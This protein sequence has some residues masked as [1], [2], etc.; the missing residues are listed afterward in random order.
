MMVCRRL[1][2]GSGRVAPSTVHI[3][4]ERNADKRTFSEPCAGKAR[5]SSESQ[6]HAE[7]QGTRGSVPR[8]ASWKSGDVAGAAGRRRAARLDRACMPFAKPARRSAPVRFMHRT[9]AIR[10]HAPVCAV[11][12]ANAGMAKA[13][14]RNRFV[15]VHRHL[16]LPMKEESAKASPLITLDRSRRLKGS[17]FSE[18]F[19]CSDLL[20]VL[21]TLPIRAQACVM[22][23][24]RVVGVDGASSRAA[25]SQRRDR[26]RQFI[27]AS[28]TVNNSCA[29]RSLAQLG[30]RGS[31][32][33]AA[34]VRVC[35]LFHRPVYRR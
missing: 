4:D 22:P 32:A 12:A 19:F 1:R 24:T 6:E 26:Q 31:R 7:C 27:Q 23:G 21:S 11:S 5:P 28:R 2:R 9:R 13:H 10:R 18:I 17:S 25:H 33:A 16:S 34:G 29:S 8:C 14:V 15:M 35:D 20:T 3:A 30:S